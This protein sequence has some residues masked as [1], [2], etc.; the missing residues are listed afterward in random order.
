MHI[1]KGTLTSS[2]V[3]EDALQLIIF[4][5]LR[6]ENLQGG[7]LKLGSQSYNPLH[8]HTVVKRKCPYK[9]ALFLHLE[10]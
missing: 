6:E 9:H 3:F 5:S 10:A 8:T 4:L 1:L 7:F 2:N